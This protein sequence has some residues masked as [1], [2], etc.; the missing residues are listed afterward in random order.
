[1]QNPKITY[2]IRS[3]VYNYSLYL[4]ILEWKY[5]FLSVFVTF[6]SRSPIIQKNTQQEWTRKKQI[7]GNMIMKITATEGEEGE[8]WERG[9]V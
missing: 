9:F 5:T 3:S 6:D 7:H 2:N 1:M 4:Y 8:E